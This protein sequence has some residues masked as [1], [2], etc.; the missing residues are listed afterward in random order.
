MQNFCYLD[1]SEEFW[2]EKEVLKARRVKSYIS[3]PTTNNITISFLCV[4][5][6]IKLIA[7]EGSVAIV[8]GTSSRERGMKR[9]GEEG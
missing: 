8:K 1:S 7:E 6:S 9:R 5:V 2:L 3:T 4:L